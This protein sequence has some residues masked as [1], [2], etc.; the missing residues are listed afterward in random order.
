MTQDIKDSFDKSAN[1]TSKYRRC[2]GFE[3]QLPA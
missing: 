3:K 2:S 1:Q